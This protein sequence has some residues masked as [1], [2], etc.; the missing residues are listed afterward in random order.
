MTVSELIAELQKFDPDLPVATD[1]SDILDPGHGPLVV[2]LRAPFWWAG[3][4]V[5][6]G[7]KVEHYS[8]I[9]EL[10]CP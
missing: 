8:N 5:V 6:L 2:E 9:G 1:F 4:Y 3:D 7:P 10:I